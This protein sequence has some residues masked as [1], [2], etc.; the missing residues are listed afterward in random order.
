M[1]HKLFTKTLKQYLRK[2]LGDLENYFH[3]KN[4][5]KQS[6]KHFLNKKFIDKLNKL[7]T[8][9]LMLTFKY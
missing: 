2:F 8:L 1:L 4:L 3:I 9:K 6:T 5:K 7:K